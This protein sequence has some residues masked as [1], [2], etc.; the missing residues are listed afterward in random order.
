V[1][2]HEGALV[3]HRAARAQAALIETLKP[4]LHAAEEME[5]HEQAGGV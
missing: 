3:S 4:E 2:P 5:R 1:A